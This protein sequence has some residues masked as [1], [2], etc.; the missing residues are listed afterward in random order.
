MADEKGSERVKSLMVRDVITVQPDDDLGEAIS[1]MNE[2]GVSA[3]PVVDNRNRCVGVLST[4]DLL[5]AARVQGRIAPDPDELPASASLSQADSQA[6]H[7]QRKVREIMA[8]D[9]VSV[10]PEV[11]ILTAAREMVRSRVH[12]LVVLDA[13]RR[14]VGILSTMDFLRALTRED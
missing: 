4:T 6:D 1:L 5:H 13:D 9:L 3:V 12:R 11:T 8:R 2:N 10:T 7:P 14:V